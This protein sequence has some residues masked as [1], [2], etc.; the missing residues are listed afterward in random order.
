MIRMWTLV[1]CALL[2]GAPDSGRPEIRRRVGPA[3]SPEGEAKSYLEELMLFSYVENSYVVNL[4]T[5][6][7]G[8]VNNLRF[9]DHDEVHVQ[10]RGVQREEGS[11]PRYGSA[12][13]R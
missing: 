8:D 13:G 3:G 5:P 9:Y 2:V 12:T 4:E 6:G 1:L 7:R 11:S 10:R